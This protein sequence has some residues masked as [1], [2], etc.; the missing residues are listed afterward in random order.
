MTHNG[1]FTEL[2]EA[3]ARVEADSLPDTFKD[4][5]GRRRIGYI[6]P[7]MLDNTSRR[8]RFS[9]NASRDIFFEE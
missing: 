6:T 3:Q 7:E 5:T 8:V 9:Y 2:S 4:K 1:W